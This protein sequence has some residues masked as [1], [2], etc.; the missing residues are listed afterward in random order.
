MDRA[1]GGTMSAFEVMWNG[2]YRLVTTPPSKGRPPLPMDHPYY[3][4]IESM[5]AD[6]DLDRTRM[7]AALES[8]LERDLI[9]DAVLAGS[10][11]E[12]NS[13]WALRDDVAQVGRDGAP[14]TFDVSLPIGAMERYVADLRDALP[15]AIG[16]HQ[17]WVFGHL[18]DGNLHVIVQV[19]R[20]AY[21]EARPKIEALVYGP[22][23]SISGSISA[24]HG[25]GLE[26]KPWL[27]IS[28][29]ETEVAIMRA[30]KKTLDPR[31]TLNPGKIFDV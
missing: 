13:I 29:D 2:F 4:L 22:L 27:S 20:E 25:I 31:N 16:E 19:K 5:G 23:K 10:Q 21:R 17:L 18:G 14:V 28:R 12:I 7:T 30:L 8:A 1:L 24:E 11:A 15:A 3:V 26:K 9:A 6:P